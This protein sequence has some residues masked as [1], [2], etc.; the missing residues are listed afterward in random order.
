MCMLAHAM[1]PDMFIGSVS[2][3]VQSYLPV[4]GSV[5]HF[6]GLDLGDFK[7]RPFKGHNWC[8]ISGDKDQNYQEI[9][10]T[11]KVWE[12]SRLE[13]RFFDVPGM[14]HVNAAPDELEKALK[15]LGLRGSRFQVPA[16]LISG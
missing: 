4:D 6:P 5:G 12:R 9:L 3:A 7:S 15:W 8:V 2:H 13:Y 10:K 1:F 11:S 14:A 16:I